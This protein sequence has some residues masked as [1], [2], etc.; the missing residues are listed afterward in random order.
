M[1]TKRDLL[2]YGTSLLTAAALPYP[3]Q[4]ALAKEQWDTIIIGAGTAGI[5]AAVVFG[6][7]SF[8]GMSS[9]GVLP[10]MSYPPDSYSLRNQSFEISV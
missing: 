1:L 9:T 7:P 10:F 2:K 6:F 4:A 5:P 8:R 3:Y